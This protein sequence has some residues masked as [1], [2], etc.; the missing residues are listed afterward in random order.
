MEECKIQRDAELRTFTARLKE[1]EGARLAQRFPAEEDLERV[2]GQFGAEIST[3][4][5]HVAD[6]QEA[7]Q[8]SETH[9]E[10]LERQLAQLRETMLR[11]S[12]SPP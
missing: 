5:N 11:I 12:G 8:E 9:R 2:V 3:Y 6:L 1:L 7:L 4:E 10:D